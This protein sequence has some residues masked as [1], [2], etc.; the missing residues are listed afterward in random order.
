MLS[1]IAGLLVALPIAATISPHGLMALTNIFYR[2]GSLV[3]GGGHVV[4][5]LLHE[6]M[7]PTGWV[8][9]DSFLAGY[10]LAQGM[11][12]PLFTL[13][14]YLGAA[15]AP[16]HLSLLW[17]LLALFAI[18]LPGL[19]LAVVAL[20]LSTGSAYLQAKAARAALA[21]INAAVVGVLA[22]A[23]Y[24]PV[25]TSSVRNG[26]DLLIVMAAFAML[27]RWRVAPILMVAFCV[28]ASVAHALI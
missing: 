7:V 6:S 1:V 8:S 18:F 26:T 17:A 10:G 5:P 15:S 12:G 21:G 9:D 11:P 19:S 28:L 22:A 27:M 23:L 24:H 25:W 4:L 14:A 3:F 13:A 16:A 20:S 2:A